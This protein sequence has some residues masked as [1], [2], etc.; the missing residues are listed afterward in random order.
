MVLSRFTIYKL[1]QDECD[2]VK[3]YS[4]QILY[5]NI[6]REGQRRIMDATV[7]IVGAGALGSVSSEMLARAGVKKIILVDRDYVE[8][9]NLQRQTLF[10]DRHASEKTPKVV[11]AKERLL[12]IRPDLELDVHIS[13]C[14]APMLETLAGEAD[15]ILDGTDNFDTRLLINDV[16]WKLG[17]PWVYAACVEASYSSCGFVPGETP[18]YRCLVPVLPSTTLTCDTAGIIAP[19]VQMAVSEQVTTAMKILTGRLEAPHYMRVGDIWESEHN[20]FGIDQMKEETCPSCGNN[21]TYPAL[22]APQ[23]Q[24]MK[25]CGRDTVQVMDARITKASVDEVIEKLDIKVNRT[26]YFS[27]FHFDGKRLVCFNTGR[28]LIHDTDGINKART[29]I[30]RLFG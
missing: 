5:R 17:I 12:E 28:I 23:D 26:P 9:S 16:A 7:L 11:G 13:H 2:D 15:I 4:R 30:D 29:L 6:G 14:D 20:R 10:T 25:L 21:R 3:Q 1:M 27:E 19:A 18:C 8:A 22:N 24:T